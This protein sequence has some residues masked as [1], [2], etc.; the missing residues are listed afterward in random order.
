MSV[1]FGLPTVDDG[2]TPARSHL[3]AS[4]K[5][6]RPIVLV[7]GL[8]DDRINLPDGRH[9]VIGVLLAELRVQWNTCKTG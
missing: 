8:G 5:S 6:G 1:R 2:R 3:R 4:D 9:D 7:S